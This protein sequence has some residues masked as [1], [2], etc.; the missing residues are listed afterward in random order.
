M[1]SK[2]DD[3]AAALLKEKLSD[4]LWRLSNLYFIINKD[5]KKQKFKLNKYQFKFYQEMHTRNVILK[6]RQLGFTTFICI[7]ILDNVLFK[8]NF[9]GGI[10]AHTLP[11]AE[12]IFRDKIKFAYENLPDWLQNDPSFKILMGATV[13]NTS[14]LK[15]TN[16][17]MVSVGLSHRGGT[18][19]ML[20]CSEFGKIAARMPDKAKEIVTGAFP[21]VPNDGYIFIESTAEGHE[22]SFYDMCQT[23]QKIERSDREITQLDFKFHF[24]PWQSA[25]EYALSIDDARHVVVDKQSEDYFLKLEKQGITL[26]PLQKT[27]YVKQQET[28]GDLVKRE[29]PSTPEEAFEASNE[30]AIYLRQMNYIRENNHITRVLFD[31]KKPVYTF[32]DLG[33]RDLAAVWIGQQNGNAFNFIDYAEAYK[34]GWDYWIKYLN[35]LGYNYFRHYFPH[36]G[37]HNKPADYGIKNQKELAQSV[38]FGDIQIVTR[39]PDRWFDIQVKCRPALVRCFFDEVKCAEGIKRLDNYRQEWDNK[40]GVYRDNPRHDDNSNGADAFRT[41]AVGFDLLD[42]SNNILQSAGYNDTM[43]QDFSFDDYFG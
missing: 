13:N 42:Q 14:T 6:S 9:K 30:G 38:G 26:N 28:L 19:Q 2:S 20:H 37:A 17:S 35:S 24:Y 21:A 1:K 8:K 22:G 39:T 34:Q 15:L 27:W 11:D 7:L 43:T 33:S 25:D 40:L 16:G 36:D 5:G 12:S 31:P 29:Y 3:E 10:I 32:W 4:Q 23:A 41:F 18:M